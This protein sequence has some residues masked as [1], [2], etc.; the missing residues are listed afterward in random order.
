[1]RKF[2]SK[3]SSFYGW[4]IVGS[5]LLCQ[6]AFMSVSQAIVG[7]FMGPVTAELGWA[8]WQYTLGPSL[9]VGMGALSGVYAGPVVDRQGPRRLM[10]IGA[11][12]SALCCYGLSRQETLWLYLTFYLIAGLVG[13]NFFGPLVVN[14]TINKWFI[15]RRGWA[16]AL[17]SIG[18]SLAGLITP[19][20]MTAIVD[21]QGWRI[22]YMVLALFVLV[23]V[24]PMALIMRR[25]P[26]DHDLVP[27]GAVANSI[28][29]RDN[30]QPEGPS[31]TRSEALRTQSF[32][33]L[34]AGFGLNQAA[35]SSVLVHAIPFATAALFTRQNAA[36]ALTVNGLGNLLSKAVW[37]Y[38]LP[39][40]EPRRLV[41]IAYSTSALGVAAML[42]AAYTSEI[43]YLLIGFFCYGFGFGGTIPLSEYLWA[44]Y[45]G[46]AHIG[47][48]RGIG[49]PVSTV[50]AMLGPIL[51]GLWYD[52]AQCIWWVGCWSG[53]QESRWEG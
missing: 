23:I 11:L 1:M 38:C 18:I 20:T 6:F 9:A 12:I 36:L 15:R 50:G 14:A 8:V 43:R 37:G 7:I 44:T 19:L 27:D 35:L 41:M 32:W 29:D 28:A 13:W 25:T 33:L 10:L 2:F 21:S 51:V 3:N 30:F 46:R 24:V 34:V 16:L 47:A 49:Q 31:L 45:F 5:A 53:P 39:R 52:Y 42:W 17:G 40:I 4:R 26:E 22:G 48:I